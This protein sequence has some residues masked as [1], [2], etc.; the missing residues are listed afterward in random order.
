[1]TVIPL[2]SNSSIPDEKLA[3]C[4]ILVSLVTVI[5]NENKRRRC[6][7]VNGREPSET[8]C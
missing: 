3:K 5:E 7:R 2:S 1:M 6:L 8:L 4:C